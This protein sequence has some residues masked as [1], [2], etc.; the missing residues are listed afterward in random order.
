VE[1]EILQ[2]RMKAKQA[3]KM[4]EEECEEFIIATKALLNKAAIIISEASSGKRRLNQ[5][6]ADEGTT[7]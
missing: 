1:N 2:T 4:S 6:V 3:A 7:Q 5:W